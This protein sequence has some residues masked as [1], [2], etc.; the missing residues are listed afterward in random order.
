MAGDDDAIE[1]SHTCAL[2]ES[3]PGAQL[4]VVPGTSHALPIER[5]GES[6]RMIRHFLRADLPPSTLMP[7]SRAGL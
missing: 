7:I 6:V 2:Y 1:L 5:P 3:I 4:A